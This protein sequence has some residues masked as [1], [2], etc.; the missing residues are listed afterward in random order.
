M[1]KALI[2]AATTALL[3]ACSNANTSTATTEPV[4]IVETTGMTDSAATDVMATDVAMETRTKAVLVYAD[5]CRSCKV[6]DPKI[7]AVQA[8]GPMSG[9]EFVTLDYTEKDADNFYAQAKT[10]GVEEAV[11]AELDGSIK[12]GWLLLVDVDDKRVLSKVTKADETT[13]IVT[14]IQD[15][16]SQS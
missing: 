5:W 4:Q 12:T 3:T 8:M 2:L 11:R 13:N 14:K 1:Q 16:L 9:V 15:A 7:K 6:L 10:A